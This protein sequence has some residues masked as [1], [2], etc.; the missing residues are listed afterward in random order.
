MVAHGTYLVGN[1]AVVTESDLPLVLQDHVFR[2]RLAP[3]PPEFEDAPVDGR[4]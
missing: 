2:L 4:G 3:S 1:V